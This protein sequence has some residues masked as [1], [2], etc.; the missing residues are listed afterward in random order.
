MNK[1]KIVLVSDGRCSHSLYMPVLDAIKQHPMLDYH[2]IVTGMHLLKEFGETANEIEKEGYVIGSRINISYGGGLEKE[3]EAIGQ[4]IC[5]FAK[6]FS[7]IKPS[8]ILVEGDRGVAL[9]TAIAGAYMNIPIAHMFGGE[10]SGTI[11]ESARHAITKLSHLHFPETQKSAERIKKMGEEN[12]RIFTTG[13]TGVEFILNKKLLSKEEIFKKLGL[14][15]KPTIVVLQHAVNFEVKQSE[16]QMKETLKA[17]GQ[18]NLQT[19]VIYPND[20]AGSSSIIT[21]IKEFEKK[22]NVHVFKNLSFFDY[23][24]L[25]KASSVLVGNSSGAII[26]SPSLGIPAIN[27]GT[28]QQGREKAPNTI[29]VGYNAEEISKSLEKALNDKDFLALVAEC[30][31]PYNPSGKADAGKKI[32]DILADVKIDKKLLEKRISY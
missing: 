16:A 31:S 20:D 22:P 32:A 5:A 17:V 6:E 12:W 26:E 2:Y 28:R 11:D 19:V 13:S 8:I 25:L 27:I 21:V 23:L 24:S 29:N 10:V 9:A 15:N 18:T 1:K 14:E 3:A 4:W 7:K 30:K